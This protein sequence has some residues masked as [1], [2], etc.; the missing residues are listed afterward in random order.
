MLDFNSNE[1]DALIS[2][3]ISS[4]SL[5]L[6]SNQQNDIFSPQ[7]S[8]GNAL[9][10]SPELDETLVLRGTKDF[11]FLNGKESNDKVYGLAGDDFL[12]GGEGDDIVN[13]GTDRD[14]L[15]GAKGN[16]VLIDGDGG[17]L[18]VGGEGADRFWINNWDIPETPST[19]LDFNIDEDT[20]KI[21]RLGVTFESLTFEDDFWSTTIYDDGKPLAT[22]IGIDKDSLTA[23]SFIFGDASL[24]NQLQT[25]LEQSVTTSETPGAT[26]A[27][28]TPDGFTWKGAAGVS[29]LEAQTAMQPDDIFGIASITKAF[30][31]ATVLKV[32][33]SGKI[34]LDDTLAQRLPEIAKNFPGSEDITLRQLLNGS[35]G[36]P[37]FNFI[38]EFLTDLETG[39]FADKS[40][41]EIVAYVYGEP[42]FSGF[43]STPIWAYTNTT[44]IIASLMV[45][46]ATGETVC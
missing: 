1:S 20:I 44:D 43:Q 24:A 5:G 12:N 4:A 31:G 46:Q 9:P 15:V 25:K 14:W 41:E 26:Q 6:I 19:I 27:V 28:I 35:S 45:E 30:A 11:D 34:S 38:E 21:G 17:D 40:P 36:I 33:E 23:E 16:D 22:L 2:Q 3:D 37:S 18:M 29:N 39:T 32:V 7:A 8:L 10:L 13:G 42:L